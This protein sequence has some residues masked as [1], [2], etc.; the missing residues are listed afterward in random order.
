[1]CKSVIKFHLRALAI[2]WRTYGLRNKAKG[3]TWHWKATFSSNRTHPNVSAH[4][5]AYFPINSSTSII[6][7]IV[8]IRLQATK[9]QGWNMRWGNGD[10][11]DAWNCRVCNNKCYL[12]YKCLLLLWLF[13]LFAFENSLE[14]V[15][16]PVHSAAFSGHV[17]NVTWPM[18][19]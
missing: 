16:K 19:G 10:R 7:A 8:W 1:M 11:P 2:D 4:Y 5:V 6:N 18:N 13:F 14:R 17:I 3:L 9:A 12:W 15:G